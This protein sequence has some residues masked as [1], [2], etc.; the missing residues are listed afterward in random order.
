MGCAG[1]ASAG[2][3]GDFMS[4]YRERDWMIDVPLWAV[5]PY[6]VRND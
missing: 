5:G 4:D 6:L 3:I 1:F 2:F